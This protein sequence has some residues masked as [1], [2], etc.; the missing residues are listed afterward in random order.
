MEPGSWK[1]HKKKIRGETL[2]LISTEECDVGYI[3][4]YGKTV[5]IRACYHKM[6]EIA[7]KL[8][9]TGLSR[10]EYIDPIGYTALILAC[11]NK[12][13]KVALKL[14][15]TG[16]SIPEYI[17]MLGYTA[18]FYAIENGM[19]QVIPILRRLGVSE[20][21]QNHVND[22]VPPENDYI[23]IYQP[24]IINFV[25]Q[26]SIKCNLKTGDFV[27]GLHLLQNNL[28]RTCGKFSG[29]HEF[30]SSNQQ[31]LNAQVLSV[32]NTNVRPDDSAS[33]VDESHVGSTYTQ[34]TVLQSVISVPSYF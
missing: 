10:P 1:K 27:N 3:D 24:P 33:M 30:G 34:G 21:R 9:G 7:L 23:Y 22:F 13:D 15:D 6:E 29:E 28:C 4:R 11:K 17:D 5:L 20:S 31:G 16:S 12:M 26:P 2:G 8:I 32:L 25:Y 18:L 19:M 14:I